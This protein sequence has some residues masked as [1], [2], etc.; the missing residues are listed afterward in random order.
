M[1]YEQTG[2]ALG[3][4]KVFFLKINGFLLSF[5]VLSVCSLIGLVFYLLGLS[6]ANIITIYIL[7]III[8]S[9]VASKSIYG[10]FSSFAG[11]LL[12]N[13]L[14]AI[15]RF[16]LFYFDPQYSITTIIM[17]L[18]SLVI[19]YA[20]GQIR[21][22]FNQNALHQYRSEVLL[23]TSQSLQL[24]Q[25]TDEIIEVVFSQMQKLM[26]RTAVIF[27]VDEGV[28]QEALIR[29]SDGGYEVSP[30]AVEDDR[31]AIA[32]W[33]ENH[34]QSRT[35][36]CIHPLYKAL[37]FIIGTDETVY[38][39]IGIMI[40][41]EGNIRGFTYNLIAAM[42][43]EIAL[44]METNILR[45]KNE[46][47]LLEAETERLHNNLLRSVSH[48]LRTPLTSISGNADIL[49]S[50]EEQIEPAV[51]RQIYRD[52][53]S[54]SEWLI[55]MIENL[56]FISRIDNG[57]MSAHFQ[58]ELLQEVLPDVAHSMGRNKMGRKITVDVP[59]ELLMVDM[60]VRLFIQLLIN[61]ID[62]AVKF[63][64]SDESVEIRLFRSG[65]RAVIEVADRGRGVPDQDK[66]RI[67]DIYYT[68]GGTAGDHSRG[69][70]LGL[71]LCR[72]IADVHGGE[73]YVRD[74]VPHGAVFG[75]SLPI[76]EVHL[77]SEYTGN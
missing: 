5:V 1:V 4:R 3:I 48:N 36:A 49:L 62:N 43:D 73:L 7:G 70:G 64:P 47:I 35:C 40:P 50:S 31:R 23:E 16:N 17:L 51:R 15:P 22:Q 67:F 75:I 65:E 38:A 34:R 59:D 61:L 12:F 45:E 29:N 72:V 2:A 18:V 74:N 30:D 42:L 24:V 20:M 57:K 27:P 8:I 19:S 6:E 58:S 76:K 32:E 28:L 53:Y 55:Q 77:E 66:E 10:I 9:C 46:K 54:D 25:N 14:Y 11:V 21:E 63:S 44:A 71:F 26:N 13:C 39:V 68:R 69:I 33:L 56:L 37:Y 60:D 52:I 41:K